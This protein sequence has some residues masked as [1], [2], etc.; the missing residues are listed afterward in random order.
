[1]DEEL[2]KRLLPRFEEALAIGYGSDPHRA[3]ELLEVLLHEVHENEYRGLIMLY[4]ALFLS[5]DGRTTEARAKLQEV[6]NLWKRTPEH[7]ARMA[8]MDALLDEA[9]GQA[10]RTLKK[11]NRIIKQYPTLWKSDDVHDLYEELQFNR[12]R[13][14]ATIDDR[15][16]ALPVLEECLSFQRPK[17]PELYANLGICYFEAEKWEKAVENLKLAL[18]KGLSPDYSSAA[19]YYLGRVSY[20]KGTLPRAVKE[21]ELA[22]DDAT[23]AGTSRKVIYDALAKSYRYLGL[24]EESAKYA[25]LAKNSA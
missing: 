9:D 22:L 13:L 15:R 23:S 16:L 12:G 20:L 4:E 21:F 7:K 1:M 11:L 14:L 18:S 8:V 6:T 5:R 19:H 17:H 2:E 3:V 10:S 24:D 25:R